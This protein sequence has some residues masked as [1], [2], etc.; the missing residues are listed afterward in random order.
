MSVLF[1]ALAPGAYQLLLEYPGEDKKTGRFPVV[2]ILSD[3]KNVHDIGALPGMPVVLYIGELKTAWQL[4]AMHKA[5][6]YWIYPTSGIGA[7][8]PPPLEIA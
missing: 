7:A 2:G 4:V 8:A 6:Q 5:S 3:V 1:V